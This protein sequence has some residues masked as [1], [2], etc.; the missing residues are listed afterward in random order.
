MKQRDS[1]QY[2]IGVALALCVVCSLSVSAAYVFLKPRQDANKL[3]DRQR[4]IVDAAGLADDELGISASELTRDQ[5]EELYRV[6]EERFVDLRSGNYTT[7]VDKDYDPREVV[8]NSEEQYIEALPE[9]IKNPL[10]TDLRER[11]VRVYLIKDFKDDSVVKQVVLPV[12]GKGLWST[13]YGY[14][15][16]KKDIETVQGLT[17]YEHGETP[18]L[19]GE[20][21]NVNWKAQWVGREVFGDSGEP[22]LGVS[23]GPAP[24]DNPYLV[25]GLSGATITSNGVTDLLRYWV[26]DNA[27]GPYLE[28][29]KTELA[30]G[31]PVPTTAGEDPGPAPA[32]D[33]SDGDQSDDE[34]P[35]VERKKPAA[36]EGE[37]E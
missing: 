12:Y 8:N 32:D 7:E 14:L 23:K 20:V 29:L 11:I 21:D 36:T 31:E 5:V 37:A 17:F 35:V 13:L 33:A 9:G 27:Y 22:E 34:I 24:S 25:D 3:L 18:G 2:T 1:L 10:G 30:G 15:A 19:G 16:L 6:V 4:N 26:S 28:K